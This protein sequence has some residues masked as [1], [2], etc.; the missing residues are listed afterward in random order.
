ML[1]PDIVQLKQF[2]SSRLGERVAGL[3]AQS[4]ANMWPSAKGDAMLVIGFGT[5]YLSHY[6]SQ[7]TPLV[8]AMPAEQGAAAWPLGQ[9]NHVVLTHDAELPL[10]NNSINRVLLIHSVEYSE[11][12]NAMMQEVWRVLVP[13]GRV[14]AIVPNRV[15]F[16]SGSARTPFGFGRPFN[17][18]QLR[19]L[20][21]NH[22]FTITRSTSALFAP[23]YFLRISRRL[24]EK[25]EKLG[26]FLWWFM[27]GLL[28]M[29]AEKQLYASIKEPVFVRKPYWL[30]VGTRQTASV[31]GKTMKSGG[32][33]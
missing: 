5:P 1:H 10:Q 21:T 28:L 29:E 9:A 18:L 12:L 20:L 11:H 2:Y 15:S 25:I 32:E 8:I 3:I 27:G 6:I 22:H 4:L 24:G 33:E 30:R 13:G 7:A 26:R 19:A 14:L 23:P 17:V 16:W 31:G